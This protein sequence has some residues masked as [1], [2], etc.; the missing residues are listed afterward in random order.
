MGHDI[1]T[2]A[3]G[4]QLSME[5]LGVLPM[6]LEGKSKPYVVHVTQHPLVWSNQYCRSL[7]VATL[8]RTILLHG[9]KVRLHV[10][11]GTHA[12]LESWPPIT[13]LVKKRYNAPPPPG[14]LPLCSHRCVITHSVSFVKSTLIL[15]HSACFASCSLYTWH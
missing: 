14:S 11:D 10:V 15:W 4:S 9:F 5:V 13:D 1:G 8:A 12:Y 3:N 6:T 7:K 2:I